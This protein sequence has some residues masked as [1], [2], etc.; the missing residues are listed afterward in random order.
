MSLPKRIRLDELQRCRCQAISPQR[1]FLSGSI[2]DFVDSPYHWA[3]WR[4]CVICVQR[5]ISEGAGINSTFGGSTPLLIATLSRKLG[6]VQELISAGANVNLQDDEGRS[7]LMVAVHINGIT[8]AHTLLDAGA[9][10]DAKDNAG[11][12]AL[13]LDNDGRS[14]HNCLK[15]LIQS[16]ANV[17]VRWQGGNSALHVIHTMKSILVLLK[18]GVKINIINHNGQ[19]ALQQ[20]QCQR[21]RDTDIEDLLFAAG[22]RPHPLLVVHQ[23]NTRTLKEECRR[24]I[25]QQFIDV[26]AHTHLFHRVAELELPMSLKK[27]VVYDKTLD[28][29]TIPCPR[30]DRMF[31]DQIGLTSHLR[32]HR[33]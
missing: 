13:C 6:L 4:G 17:N 24:V 33:N 27:F 22:E 23:S 19:N 25:R 1:T 30:C 7:P 10:V 12:T 20:Y 18:A 8:F 32:S 21:R 15:L 9:D 16:G 5:H 29:A 11:K 28:E 26:D 31:C 14:A 3:A 2:H